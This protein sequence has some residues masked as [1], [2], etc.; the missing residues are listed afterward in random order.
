MPE[1]AFI[2]A[3]IMKKLM[4]SGLLAA[5]FVATATQSPVQAKDLSE[6]S[7]PV[8]LTYRTLGAASGITI[9][10][11]VATMRT[12]PEETIQGIE[13]CATEFSS[14]NEPDAIQYSVATI[15]GIAIGL[16]NGLLKGLARGVIT[17]A[18]QGFDNPFSVDSFSLGEMEDAEF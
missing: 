12:I 9:G 14:G 1:T 8:E 4:T 10:T 18:H 3:M 11:P 17:G 16:T 6:I 2:E 7:N 15:P 13:S 5:L